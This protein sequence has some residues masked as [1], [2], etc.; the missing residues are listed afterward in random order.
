MKKIFIIAVFFAAAPS[1]AF[2]ATTCPPNFSEVN[3]G[4][5]YVI[6]TGS[7]P[8]GYV[9]VQG[10]QAILPAAGTFDNINVFC[11]WN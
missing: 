6:T 3:V 7:C 1:F 11:S 5:T 9:E 10:G 4:Q 2:G 8:A